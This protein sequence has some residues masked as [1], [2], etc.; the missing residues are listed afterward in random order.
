MEEDILSQEQ[1]DALTQAVSDKDKA[2]AGGEGSAGAAGGFSAGQSQAI[3]DTLNHS[4][5]GAVPVLTET[6]GAQVELMVNDVADA[7]QEAVSTL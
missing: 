6:L 2:P 1:I 7:S 3:K 4:F 5:A